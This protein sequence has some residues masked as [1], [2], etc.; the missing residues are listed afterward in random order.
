[1][2]ISGLRLF[3]RLH[4]CEQNPVLHFAGRFAGKGDGENFFRLLAT[5]EQ[6]ENPLGQE[7]G[8]TG[9]GGRR[10][11]KRSCRVEGGATH[12]VIRRTVGSKSTVRQQFHQNSP[13]PLFVAIGKSATGKL[14]VAISASIC[15]ASGKRLRG[16]KS[17]AYCWAF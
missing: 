9:T 3:L 13:A 7:S 16:K 14:P 8:L 6:G 4:E 15:R 12:L 17:P 2:R 5:S 11:G 10:D 1:M